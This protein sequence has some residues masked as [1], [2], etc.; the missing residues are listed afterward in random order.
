MDRLASRVAI[1][2]AG[3][4]GLSA[5]RA[6]SQAEKNG[7]KIPEIVCFEKQND[8]GGMWNYSWRTGVDEFGEPVHSSMYRHL[9]SNAPKECLEFGDYSFYQHF[10]RSIPSFLPREM[11]RDYIVGRACASDV[12]KYVCFNSVVR[13]VEFVADQKHFTLRFHNL[14]TGKNKSENFDYVIVAVGHFSVPNVPSFDGIDSFPGR[15]L[16]SHDF[17]DAR[18]FTNQNIL[19]VGGALSAEDIALQTYKFGAK[20]ITISY[21]TKP[22]G[23]GWPPE[24]EELPLLTHIDGR[25]VHFKDGSK[26]TIDSIILCTGYKHH[27]PFLTEDLQLHTEN[28]LYPDQ[29]FKGIF[30]Q[31][32]PRLAYLG[33][34]KFYYSLPFFDAQAWYLRDVILGRI[35]LP[36]E[37]D[38]ASDIRLWRE[39]GKQL[40]GPSE[41][42]DFQ[43]DYARQL[44]DVTDYPKVD[45]L[46]AA[47]MFKLGRVH[48]QEN[49]L[50]FRDKLFTSPFTGTPSV[51][52]PICW[53]DAKDDRIL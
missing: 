10:Q 46:A 51:A 37:E 26:R 13:H 5:L 48:K 14:V 43:V 9:W 45:L 47:A 19:V 29:L 38:R 20:S 52:N 22:F 3:P 33:M 16:H 28:C 2:G 53:I 39:R 42:I 34:Q 17:R 44:L 40:S 24:I 18:Q 21:R 15:I 49:I 25:T 50:E 31:R 41:G 4:S 35:S 8:W 32:Q 6:F 12:Q 23:Y 1:I 30:L 11:I 7:E 36:E 27:F